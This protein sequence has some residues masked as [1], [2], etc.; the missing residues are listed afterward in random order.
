V[1]LEFLCKQNH[2]YGERPFSCILF[3][4]S[5]KQIFGVP[6][7]IDPNLPPVFL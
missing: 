2:K 1:I 4:T 7:Y 5:Q 6:N 3:A